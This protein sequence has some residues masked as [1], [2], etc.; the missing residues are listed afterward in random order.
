VDQRLWDYLDLSNL[1]KGTAMALHPPDIDEGERILVFGPS[2]VGKSLGWTTIARLAI[3][4]K[5]DATFYVV[6]T[7]RSVGRM[8]SDPGMKPY[9]VRDGKRVNVISEDVRGWEDLLDTITNFQGKMRPQ[10]WLVIDLLTPSWQWCQDHFT[11]RIFSQDL[12]QY[13]I[14]VREDLRDRPRDKD[15]KMKRGGFEGYSDWPVINAIWGRLKEKLVWCPGNLY[16]TAGIKTLSSETADREQRAMFGNHGVVPEG[17]KH[18]AFDFSTVLWFS[19]SAGQY[20]VITVKDRAR[21]ALE[22]VPLG[23]EP[24]NDFAMTYLVKT[25][26]WQL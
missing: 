13:F 26:Q 19:N 10:D 6:C 16:A 25:A 14:Q 7:D 9:L 2:G 22:G 1:R 17:Q 20:E 18:L 24:G 11:H 15:V 3:R 12:D 21:P 5:S 8:L 4:T 23:I